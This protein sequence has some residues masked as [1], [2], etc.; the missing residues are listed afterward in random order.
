MTLLPEDAPSPP[1][2]NFAPMVDFLFLI[3]TAF[4]VIATAR[5]PLF[6]VQVQLKEAD[7][8]ALQHLHATDNTGRAFNITITEGGDYFWLTQGGRLPIK[9]ADALKEMFQW[10][11]QESGSFPVYLHIDKNAKWEGVSDVIM[12]AKQVGLD[13]YPVH[14]D[15]H[16]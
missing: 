9:G 1:M 10:L 15:I 4:A 13:V 12:A 16:K 6:D 8:E 5:S 11:T 3:V 2:I 14:K 7:K